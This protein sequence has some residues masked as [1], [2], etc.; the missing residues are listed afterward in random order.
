MWLG[1][2]VQFENAGH[3]DHGV[4]GMAILEHGVFQCFGAVDE[5][6]AAAAA[7]ILDDPV[8]VTVTTDQEQGGFRR[9]RRGRFTFVHDT[10]TFEGIVGWLVWDLRNARRQA[11]IVLAGDLR[12]DFIIRR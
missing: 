9:I 10:F 7:L 2:H 5:E 6:A 12:P 1:G 3:H 11:R 8:A 4:R